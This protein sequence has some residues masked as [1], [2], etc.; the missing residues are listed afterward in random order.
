MRQTLAWFDLARYHNA[1][2]VN[3]DTWIWT[4]H[5]TAHGISKMTYPVFQEISSISSVAAILDAK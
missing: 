4:L 2:L 5:S 3:L 1:R